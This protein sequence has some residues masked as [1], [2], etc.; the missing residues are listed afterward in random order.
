MKNLIVKHPVRLLFSLLLLAEIVYVSMSLNTCQVFI[1]ETKDPVIALFGQFGA[2]VL[3]I[4]NAVA[5]V[6]LIWFIWASIKPA[7]HSSRAK[8]PGIPHK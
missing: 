7:G 5:S 8:I 4:L 2:E 6:L 3:V 1:E